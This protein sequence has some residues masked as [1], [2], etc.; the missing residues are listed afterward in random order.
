MKSLKRNF[1]KFIK[2]I[3]FQSAPQSDSDNDSK[4][5]VDENSSSG[6]SS[7]RF[8]PGDPANSKLKVQVELFSL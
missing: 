3:G 8:A 6:R 5:S 1:N 4:S 7:S 2:K